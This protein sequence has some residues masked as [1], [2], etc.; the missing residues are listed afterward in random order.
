VLDDLI[1]YNTI[2]TTQMNGTY[3]NKASGKTVQSSEEGEKEKA[4]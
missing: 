1:I 3:E 2:L 4:L